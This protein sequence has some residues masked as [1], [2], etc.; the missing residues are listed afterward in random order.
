MET[1]P[2]L[3][4][5][6]HQIRDGMASGDSLD[7]KKS[8]VGNLEVC[9]A[10]ELEIYHDNITHLS[11][12]VESLAAS[13]NADVK[14]TPVLSNVLK[15]IAASGH[16][17]YPWNMVKVLWAKRFEMVLSDLVKKTGKQLT[18]DEA[19]SAK[20]ISVQLRQRENA[21]FTMQRLAELALAGDKKYKR[22]GRYIFAIARN[23]FGIESS[24]VECIPPGATRP[25][26]NEAAI[27]FLEDQVPK[28]PQYT[29]VSRIPSSKPLIPS[30]SAGSTPVERNR[31]S[32]RM[33]SKYPNG[34]ER[35]LLRALSRNPAGR[36]DNST[37][38]RSGRA[39]RVTVNR[40][41]KKSRRRGPP[42]EKH[43]SD[44][45]QH[46]QNSLILP[47]VQEFDQLP[48]TM[49]DSSANLSEPCNDE[50]YEE[51]MYQASEMGNSSSVLLEM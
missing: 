45:N 11:R 25:S 20:F 8:T 32:S 24:M 50:E 17:R 48:T 41:T 29:I 6:Y 33:P 51:L 15:E 26:V 2:S 28:P 38:L 37:T 13:G 18:E 23:V 35:Q 3:G 14:W 27:H 46:S 42:N 7:I 31:H 40:T 4:F 22:C 21:P 16:L 44:A 30:S 36:R 43:S 19:S 1:C 12:F 5:Q 9:R 10:V 39:K 49:A 47:V 34:T